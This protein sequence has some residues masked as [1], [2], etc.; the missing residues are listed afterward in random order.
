MQETNDIK[1]E[2]KSK[3]PLIRGSE[4]AAGYDICSATDGSLLAGQRQMLPT[5]VYMSL[6]SG[7]YAHICPRSGLA[8][9]NGIQVLAGIC[10]SDYRG[11]YK[12][13]LLNT[14]NDTYDFK[15]GDKIAQVIFK[16]FETVEFTHVDELSETN[17]GSG[18]FGSTDL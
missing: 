7:Y 5:G 10:D 11:E 18:G 4:F 12:V 3:Y 6:P 1:V 14:G 8:Y 16:K 15:K 2:I 17:R 13:I 9:K